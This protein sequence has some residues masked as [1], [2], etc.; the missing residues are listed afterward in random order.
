MVHQLADAYLNVAEQILLTERVPMRPRA[1]LELAYLNGL[2]PDHLYGGTQHKTLHARLSEDIGVH[3]E[4]SRFYRT[5]PGVFFLRQFQKEAHLPQAFRD[6]YFAPPRRKELKR[7]WVLTIAAPLSVQGA[8]SC[9]EYDLSTLLRVLDQRSYHYH[10]YSIVRG[11]PTLAIVH[12]FVV[13]YRGHRI[14]S[15]RTGRFSPLTDPLYGQRSVGVG[16]AVLMGDA[17]MLYDSVHGIVANGIG[18]LGYA[19]GLPRRLAEKARYQN[20]LRPRIAVVVPRSSRH[21]NVVHVVMAYRCPEEFTPSKGALSVN[22]LRWVDAIRPGNNLDDFDDTSR[23]LFSKEHL[24]KL[25]G[26]SGGHRE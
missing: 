3:R 8:T 9:F 2:L 20:E 17:D 21:P 25:E 1:I 26:S 19:I 5:S 6:E 16:G 11:D 4:E 14:L 18:E 15:Y 23:F 12:S 10:P 13:V 7:E 24:S 22:D